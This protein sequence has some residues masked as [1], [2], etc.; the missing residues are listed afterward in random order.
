MLL[1]EV[2]LCQKIS[3]L[4]EHGEKV[5]PKNL[6]SNDSFISLLH[7]LPNLRKISGEL[8]SLI[9]VKGHFKGHARVAVPA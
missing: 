6:T 7:S 3:T 4:I 1:F 8:F 9:F 5:G 2:V